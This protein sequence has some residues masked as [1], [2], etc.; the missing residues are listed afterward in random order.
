MSTI[1]HG[2]GTQAIF[3]DR[4]DVFYASIHGDPK[5]EF[6]FFLGHADET[7][8]GEGVGFNANFPLPAGAPNEAWFE[9]LDQPPGAAAR[10]RARA[11]DRVAG[12]RHLRGDPISHFKLQRARVPNAWAASWPASAS[13][14][15]PAGRRLCDRG[16]RPQRG[17]RAARF[18][19][20]APER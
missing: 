1:H 20:A 4:A 17:R 11:A 9:A 5:T 13:R 15:V 2:N 12:R 6:P 3:Y 19:A 14:P 18:P 8:A 16:G 10:L 7:G